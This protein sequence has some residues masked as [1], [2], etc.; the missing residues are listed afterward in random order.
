MRTIH[1]KKQMS[2]EEAAKLEGYLLTDDTYDIVVG[3]E[4]TQ[5]LKE[6]G[7]PLLI[8][9]K[10]A[11]KQNDV[12]SAYPVFKRAAIQYRSVNRGIA[13]GKFEVQTE[14][15]LGEFGESTYRPLKKNGQVSSTT[16]AIASDELQ[17]TIDKVNGK[18]YQKLSDGSRVAYSAG[19]PTNAIM[20]YMDRSGRYPYCRLTS[21]NMNHPEMFQETLPMV[22]SVNSA[23]K[24]YLP[25][26][27]KNQYEVVSKTSP[28]FY[29]SGTVFTTLTVNLNFPTAVHKDKGD[30][31]DGFGVMS[32]I[33]VGRFNGCYTVFPQYRVAAD[34]QTGDVLLAD[35]HEWH[36][37]TQKRDIDSRAERVACVFYYRE[38]MKDCESAEQEVEI[39]KRKHGATHLKG[40]ANE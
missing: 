31:E 14:K 36:G 30:L 22:H 27:Y 26:R 19:T 2:D 37:N 15:Y 6:D 8:L 5:V 10:S 17:S 3:S 11:I 24:D 12:I 28:D 7:T 35:V 20:G 29:I 38:E 16:I 18:V 33:R 34:M 40:K 25:E 39:A 13:S 1:V 4:T 23:F 9:I 21:F 32:C